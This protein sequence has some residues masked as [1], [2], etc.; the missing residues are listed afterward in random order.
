MC[1]GGYVVNS[2]SE[3]NMLAI[4]GMSY[5]DR[6][7]GI[8]N[9]AVIVTIGPKDFGDNPLDGIVGPAPNN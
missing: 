1:P 3:E 2:S 6:S 8:A 4:N 5:H 9:S 7:S